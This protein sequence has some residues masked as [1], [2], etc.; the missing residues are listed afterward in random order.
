MRTVYKDKYGFE[1]KSSRSK[2]SKVREYFSAPA[3]K[4]DISDVEE[5]VVNKS[6]IVYR[7][8][9]ERY[10]F[11]YRDGVLTVTKVIPREFSKRNYLATVP[12]EDID[13]K[14]ASTSDFKE[15]CKLYDSQS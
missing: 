12:H 11:N 9:S 3:S 10:S 13:V 5:Y 7:V 1:Y 14:F 15:F 4:E 8:Q 2:S 6:T